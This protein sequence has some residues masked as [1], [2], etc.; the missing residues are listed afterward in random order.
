MDHYKEQ[1][2]VFASIEALGLELS[3]I[4][5]W[6]E[7][8]E[9]HDYHVS[10][11]IWYSAGVVIVSASWK[12]TLK[13]VSSMKGANSFLVEFIP[14]IECQPN[15][16]DFR[17]RS[18]MRLPDHVEIQ[19]WMEA[20]FDAASVLEAIKPHLPQPTFNKWAE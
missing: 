1:H 13:P 17:S 10:G 16:F 18:G 15:D 5:V 20:F 7:H 6:S 8:T 12:A 19:Q 9:W 3:N 11:E 14:V 2:P 4:E